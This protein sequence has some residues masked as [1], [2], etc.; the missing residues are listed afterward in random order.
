VGATPGAESSANNSH[1]KPLLFDY[2]I[3]LPVLLEDAGDAGVVDPFYLPNFLPKP[4]TGIVSSFLECLLKT[5]FKGKGNVN[6][7]FTSLPKLH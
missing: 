6:H 1:P 7:K 5:I 3:C 2:V 4:D